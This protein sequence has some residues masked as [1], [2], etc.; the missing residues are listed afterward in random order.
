MRF[1]APVFVVLVALPAQTVREPGVTLRSGC[2]VD[3]PGVA[4][5]AAGTPVKVRFALA[6][7]GRDCFA[8]SVEVDGARQTGYLLAQH[9]EGLEAFEQARRA[10]PPISLPVV[11]RGGNLAA[12]P[13]RPQ[14]QPRQPGRPQPSV[15]PAPQ[16]SFASLDDPGRTH[17]NDS[18]RGTTYLIDFWAIWCGPCR[19]EMPNLHRAYEKYKHR[20]F[21]I[22][23][24]SFDKS[25]Q[26]VTRYRQGRWKMPWLH[27]YVDGGFENDAARRFGVSGIPTPIL[28]DPWGRMIARGSLLRGSYLDHTLDRALNGR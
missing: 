16:F 9:L 5:L 27:G 2:P 14:A 17:T 8:V 23:S 6:S 18:L 20:D 7:E 19:S 21:Q 4:E 10:A 26:E 24:L 25:P 22:L 28:V 3:A 15:Q 1:L 13:A 11:I 12:P